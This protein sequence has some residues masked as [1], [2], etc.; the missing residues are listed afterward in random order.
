MS[1]RTRAHLFHDL[2]SMDFDGAF[3]QV[4]IDRDYFVRGTIDDHIHDPSFARRQRLEPVLHF[5]AACHGAAIL[6]ILLQSVIDAIQ[7]ILIQKRLLN[8][9]WTSSVVSLIRYA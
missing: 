1:H 3:A 2:G 5:G 8:K 6:G 7:K 9:F 4:Q